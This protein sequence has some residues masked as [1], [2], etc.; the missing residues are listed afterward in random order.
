MI[1]NKIILQELRNVKTTLETLTASVSILV[2]LLDE[3]NYKAFM[4]SLKPMIEKIQEQRWLYE[5]LTKI[6]DEIES[7]QRIDDDDVVNE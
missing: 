6:E 4:A 2:N 3:P 1:E 5:N 7:R